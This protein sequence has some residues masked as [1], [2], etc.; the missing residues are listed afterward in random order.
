MMSKILYILIPCYNE[1]DSIIVSSSCLVKKMNGMLSQNLI[2]ENSRIVFIDDGSNDR[3]WERIRTLHSQNSI[4]TGIKLSRNYGHQNALYAGLMEAKKFAD[5]TISLDVDLQD[6]IDCLEKMIIKFNE[7]CDIVYGVRKDRNVDSQFKR[8]TAELYYKITKMLDPDIFYNHADFRLMSKK[9]VNSLSYFT[10]Y[11]LFLRGII[12]KLGYKTGVVEYT[13]KERYIGDSKYNIKRMCALAWDGI[14]A[15][16]NMPLKIIQSIGLVIFVF[17]FVYLMVLSRTTS[18]SLATPIIG[19]A[20][21][22]NLLALGI[23]GEYISRIY[24]EVKRRPR[25]IIEE[26]LDCNSPRKNEMTDSGGRNFD[27]NH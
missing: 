12:P 15:I 2:S 3:T 19:I 5:F 8:W 17:S 10:E 26:N 14:F 24:D 27:K 6:D 18:S 11:H 4:F 23:V 9:A 20:T 13:R 25:Y 7:G 16:S 22:I 21:G 1:E